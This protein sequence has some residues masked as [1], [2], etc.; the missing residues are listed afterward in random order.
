MRCGCKC[1]DP[2]GTRG[3]SP[4]PPPPTRSVDV[5]ESCAY[6]MPS[7]ALD[8][9]LYLKYLQGVWRKVTL[10]YKV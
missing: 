6:V 2:G 7:L 4:A 3:R 5:N 8:P 9:L 1:L 10:S